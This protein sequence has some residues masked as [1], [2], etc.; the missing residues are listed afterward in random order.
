[1]NENPYEPASPAAPA[2]APSQ[3]RVLLPFEFRGSGSEYFRIWIVNLL[4]TIVTL[5][6]YSAWAKVR[7]LRYFYGNTFVDGQSFDY[8]GQPL[9]ILKGR[10]IVVAGYV[11]FIIASK[12]FPIGAGLIAI[13][14][15]FFGVPWIIMR[16]R[17]FQL[18]MTSYRNLRFNFDGTFGGA[19]SAFIGW[20]FLAVLTLG[21]LFPVW[22]RKRVQYSLDNASYGNQNFSFLTGNG[23][24]YKFC[25]I[26]FFLGLAVYLGVFLTLLGLPGMREVMFPGEGSATGVEIMATAGLMGAVLVIGGIIALLGIAGY[27]QA[28]FANA[29]FGGIMAG[30][31][32]VRSNLRAWPLIGI[33][34]TNLFAIIFTLGLYYPWA[35]VRQ[36]R[37]QLDNTAIDSD[38]NLAAFTAASGE[39]IDAVGEEVGDF[40]DV[41]FGI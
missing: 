28:S 22:V 32:F 4:L 9:A 16:S 25:L 35:K 7:R 37:Y 23:T 40:F 8:H 33:Y 2:P 1:M 41:D 15:A 27:Y 18:R 39:G 6:I 14:L 29:A 11:V 34:V 10:L 19:M 31:Q 12:M 24:Y 36:L 5:G 21:I 38:G 3:P 17:K 30:S 13:L 26:T 20:Y